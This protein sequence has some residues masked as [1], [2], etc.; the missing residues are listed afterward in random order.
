M[1][2]KSGLETLL[3]IQKYYKDIKIPSGFKNS[4]EFITP[5]KFFMMSGFREEKLTITFQAKGVIDFFN[6]PPDD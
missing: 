3:E 1:P 4:Q 5:P 6:N 2:K